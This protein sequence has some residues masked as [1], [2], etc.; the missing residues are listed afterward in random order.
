MIEFLKEEGYKYFD[1][2]PGGDNYKEKYCNFHQKIYI[3]T[4]YFFR[5][6]KIIAD[7]KYLIG[8]TLKNLILSLGGQPKIVK[9]KLDNTLAIL[10][11][12]FRLT[13]L[14][15]IGKLSSV[16][17]ERNVYVLFRILVDDASTKDFLTCE[18]INMNSYSDL[19]LYNNSNPT[20]DKKSD[21]FSAAL[22]HFSSDDILYTKVSDGVL[23]QYGW[24]TKGRKNYRF[25]DFDAEFD[26][27][28]NSYLLNDFFTAPHP[29]KQDIYEMTLETML[30]NCRKNGA[31]EVF[32]GVNQNDLLSGSIIEKVGFKVYRKFQRTKS[33]WIV[34]KKVYS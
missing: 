12:N 11:K 14:K 5:K 31:K 20:L 32:I 4:F 18:D 2:T 7:L 10:K 33:F 8:K 22:R 17:Y 24:M 9:N 21:L 23:I 15:F 3:P 13:P 19:L 28:D 1:L 29:G 34:N 25:T 30:L 6:D 16:I 27:P 26:F